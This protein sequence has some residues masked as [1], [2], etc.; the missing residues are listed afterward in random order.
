MILVRPNSLEYQQT[1]RKAWKIYPTVTKL[2]GCSATF[3]VEKRRKVLLHSPQLT[4]M[5]ETQ[6][7]LEFL[8]IEME[9]EEQI[10]F[11][12]EFGQILYKLKNTI[13]TLAEK[14]KQSAEI[15]SVFVQQHIEWPQMFSV[16]ASK[17]MECRSCG[18]IFRA[19]RSNIVTIRV[20]SDALETVTCPACGKVQAY[21]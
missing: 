13:T 14:Q 5:L 1:S 11:F 9:K 6:N 10:S 3:L 16:I 8:S 2:M 7:R 15:K 12:N 19:Y 4:L 21:K 17:L 20:S 18:E